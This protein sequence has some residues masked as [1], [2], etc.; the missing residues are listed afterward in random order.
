MGAGKSSLLMFPMPSSKNALGPANATTTCR[1]TPRG[2]PVFQLFML[3][4]IAFRTV[5][6]TTMSVDSMFAGGVAARKKKSAEEIEE[7]E[8]AR[9]RRRDAHDGDKRCRR[10]ASIVC[11]GRRQGE[12]QGVR[13]STSKQH[14][15]TPC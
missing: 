14:G 6:C 7:M 15:E 4:G 2:K 11:R 10:R 3:L 12:G 5:R 8:R 9:D 1:P 13:F